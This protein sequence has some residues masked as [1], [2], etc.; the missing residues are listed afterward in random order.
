MLARGRCE[1]RR[2]SSS[3]AR[4]AEAFMQG[5]GVSESRLPSL[6]QMFASLHFADPFT[7]HWS[8]QTVISSTSS[9][10]VCMPDGP[11]QDPL[12][13]PMHGLLYRHFIDATNEL[14]MQ[15]RS[16]KTM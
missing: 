14:A 1:R 11:Q 2:T 10:D 4:K 13:D 7:L 6:Y 8:R 12:T 5:D 15:F 9:M 16:A 3:G